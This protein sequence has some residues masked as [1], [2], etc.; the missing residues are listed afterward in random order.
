MTEAGFSHDEKDFTLLPAPRLTTPLG[1]A[2]FQDLGMSLG[3][4]MVR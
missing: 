2:V 4:V 1:V 3:D